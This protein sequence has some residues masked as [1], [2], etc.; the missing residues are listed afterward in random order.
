MREKKFRFQQY[1]LILIFLSIIVSFLTYFYSYR[2]IEKT[3]SNTEEHLNQKLKLLNIEDFY[4]DLNS[5][6]N[7]D[8][9][10][11]PKPNLPD[12]KLGDSV[13]HHQSISEELLKSLW[14]KSDNLFNIDLEKEN[15]SLVDKILE[16][17]K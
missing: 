13:M 2:M 16:N 1:F 15:E 14:V 8:D 5:S 3:R 17:Y 11:F 6:L 12:G 9:F 10:F 7:M 4:F